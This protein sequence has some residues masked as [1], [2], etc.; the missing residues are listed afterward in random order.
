MKQL[1]K[2]CSTSLSQVK[3]VLR[4][5]ELLEDDSVY[6]SSGV[7]RHIR[8][9]L[10]HYLALKNGL[11]GNHVNYNRRNRGSKVETDIEFAL[12]IISYLN[13]WLL[14]LEDNTQVITIDS[15]IAFDEQFIETFQSNQNRELL[16]MINHT[17]HHI[18]YIK[19]MAKKY[20]IEFPDEL[21][22]A[23]STASFIRSEASG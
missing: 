8:H 11:E 5:F 7:S 10:D 17:I 6:Q 20:D 12:E 1:H 4:K 14:T 18:A 21:G 13:N 19:L 3:L 15:E 22:I 2:A 23:P 16:S 9:I